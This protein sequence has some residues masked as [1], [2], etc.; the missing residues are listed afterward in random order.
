MFDNFVLWFSQTNFYINYVSQWPAPLNNVSFDAF[1][2]LCFLVYFGWLIYNEIQ[3]VIFQQKRKKK[4]KQI[5]ERK[6]AMK[7]GEIELE[8]MNDRELLE[9]YTRFMLAASIKNVNNSF[10]NLSL[11]DFSHKMKELQAKGLVDANGNV[12]NKPSLEEVVPYEE[13]VKV[14]EFA[15]LASMPTYDDFDEADISTTQTI[16]IPDE[17][18]SYDSAPEKNPAP[19]VVPILD[20]PVDL[21]DFTSEKYTESQTGLRNKIAFA[22]FISKS[23][24]HG[25]LGLLIIPEFKE[26]SKKSP[27]TWGKVLK[28]VVTELKDNFDEIYFLE[29]KGNEFFVYSTYTK[30]TITPKFKD[31]KEE[32]ITAVYDIGTQFSLEYGVCINDGKMAL[33]EVAKIARERLNNNFIKPMD[34]KLT[35]SVIA[36]PDEDDEEDDV[37]ETRPTSTHKIMDSSYTSDDFIDEPVTKVA[38]ED[39][40]IVPIVPEEDK[41]KIVVPKQSGPAYQHLVKEKSQEQKYTANV[42]TAEDN[43]FLAVLAGIDK[44]KQRDSKLAEQRQKEEQIRQ[45]NLQVLEK[46]VASHYTIEG[47]QER[48]KASSISV[49]EQKDLQRRR[50]Q[51]AKQEAKNKKRK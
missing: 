43:A 11:E 50:E 39:K 41:P 24:E 15:D 9:T 21:P 36:L 25:S 4:L 16:A 20:E 28:R 22:E 48:R 49:A 35:G 17:D 12:I 3:N 14:D 13:E 45:R 40:P 19:A 7:N 23:N 18:E 44:N 8:D 33:E 31:I 51:V 29:D 27:A 34:S 32:L 37:I 30:D 42:A 10:S 47:Q 38:I 46:Q 2:L 5:E 1:I 6:M 26:I